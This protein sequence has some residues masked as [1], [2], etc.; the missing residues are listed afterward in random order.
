MAFL[1]NISFNLPLS[2]HDSNKVR[3][4]EPSSKENSSL[5]RTCPSYWA[6][7]GK[8]CNWNSAEFTL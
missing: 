1:W 6:R 2:H 5:A 7:K 3:N 8:N 4:N